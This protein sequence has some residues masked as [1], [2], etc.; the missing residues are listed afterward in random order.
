VARAVAWAGRALGIGGWCASRS[1]EAGRAFASDFGLEWVAWDGRHEVAASIVVNATPLGSPRAM[2]STP[3]HASLSRS[4]RV[5]FDTSYV[6]PDTPFLAEGSR[7]GCVLVHGREMFAAQAALQCRLFTGED[8]PAGAFE[9]F[10]GWAS[11]GEGESLAG[12]DGR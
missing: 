6:S 4:A 9:R 10:A 3:F 1:E 8:L 2:E 12:K 7:S 11:G 5:L